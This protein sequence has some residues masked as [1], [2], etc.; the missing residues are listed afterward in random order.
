[1]SPPLCRPGGGA[2]VTRLGRR[3][4]GGRRRLENIDLPQ[5]PFQLQ[6]TGR[7][8]D[9][10]GAASHDAWRS[11][12]RRCRG[13]RQPSLARHCHR[14]RGGQRSAKRGCGRRRPLGMWTW[15]RQL[16]VPDGDSAAALGASSPRHP[17]ALGRRACAT[18]SPTFCAYLADV[19]RGTMTI[20]SCA[21]IEKL[22]VPCRPPSSPGHPSP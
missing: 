4:G 6:A 12:A 3:A 17:G 22:R 11:Q 9:R 14:C 5:V 18:S 20:N 8:R 15:S 10:V 7:Q 19:D 21:P 1:M 2:R 16:K 13:V